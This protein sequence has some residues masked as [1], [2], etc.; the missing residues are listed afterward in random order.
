MSFQCRSPALRTDITFAGASIRVRLTCLSS[1]TVVAGRFDIYASP[2]SARTSLA[3]PKGQTA[4]PP[5]CCKLSLPHPGKPAGARHS[6]HHPMADRFHPART[7]CPSASDRDR[8]DLRELRREGSSHLFWRLLNLSGHAAHRV[9]LTHVSPAA[10]RLTL[11]GLFRPH[12]GWRIAVSVRGAY[13][14]NLVLRFGSLAFNS[15]HS[16]RGG[17]DPLGVG[18]PEPTSHS[19][20][21]PTRSRVSGRPSPLQE[22]DR[23]AS[24]SGPGG[25]KQIQQFPAGASLRTDTDPA[26]ATNGTAGKQS[27]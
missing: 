21:N 19:C 20:G 8:V 18:G 6:T 4:T 5:A 16:D 25:P 10:P 9:G 26:L 11:S 13:R 1:P 7:Q 17:S 23:T 27:L 12:P 2:D 14:R 24:R 3:L 15:P 22:E